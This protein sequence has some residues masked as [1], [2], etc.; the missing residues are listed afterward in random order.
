VGR[1]SSPPRL[2][3]KLGLV[4]DLWIGWSGRNMVQL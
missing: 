4:L 3:L 2:P 1:V